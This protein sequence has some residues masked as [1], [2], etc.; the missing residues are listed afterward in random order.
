[1]AK[2]M[3]N[4]TLC[5]PPSTICKGMRMMRI[6]MPKNSRVSPLQ[7]ANPQTRAAVMIS[8]ALLHAW[9]GWM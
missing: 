4:S 7:V 5:G 1:M 9:S 3:L 6:S 2:S 8:A